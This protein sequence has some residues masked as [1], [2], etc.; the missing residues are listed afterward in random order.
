MHD[1][2]ILDP[3]LPGVVT[4]AEMERV[5]TREA[6]RLETLRSMVPGARFHVVTGRARCHRRLP[7]DLG[8]CGQES[9]DHCGR[10]AAIGH[11][12]KLAGV[13]P[14]PTASGGAAFL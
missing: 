9:L 3:A 12:H 10:M 5:A 13:D 11:R 6:N 2:M 4:A 14:L 8:R 7:L 1:L